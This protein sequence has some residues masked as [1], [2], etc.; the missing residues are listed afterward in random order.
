MKKR[1]LTVVS[2]AML[3]A[4]TVFSIGCTKGKTYG[5]T[6]P[7]G[8]KPTP[9]AAVLKD[10]Q[11]YAKET[12]VIE[13]SI[14]SICPAGGW[15]YLR[16]QTGEIYVNNHPTFIFIPPQDRRQGKGHGKTGPIRPRRSVCR[17]KRAY[18]VK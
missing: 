5:N 12:V 3:V 15:F 18:K 16:D 1:I 14:T 13:G 11:R 17:D 4:A 2:L 7:A 8:I 9:I 10:Q 6:I